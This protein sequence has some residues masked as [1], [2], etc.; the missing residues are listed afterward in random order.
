M[1]RI[2][3]FLGA[4]ALAT[5]AAGAAL[6]EPGLIIDLGGKFDKSFNESA[7]T[8]AQRWMED[9]G[10]SYRESEL[11]SEAQREQSMRRMAESGAN[12]VVVLGFANASTLE[13]V[14][15][16][17]PDTN[18][19]IVDMVV[20]APNVQSVVFKEHEGSYL[21][22]VLAAMASET[23]TVSFVGGMDVPLISKFACGYAQG[24]KAVKPDANVIVNMTGTT[25]TAWNDPVRGAELTRSQISQGS[26]VVY[27]AAGGTGIGVLQAAADEGILSIGVDSNQNHLHP[28]QVLTSMVKRVDNAVYEAFEA[29][30]NGTFEPGIKVMGLDNN[31]V[32]WAQDEY[33][34]DL[35]TESMKATVEETKERIIAGDI[36]VH[37]YTTDSSCPAY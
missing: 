30:M 16:D 5:F 37:D 6:A 9:T 25:P 31:G 33:N 19:T 1:T 29:G 7:F 26:D 13:K 35:I 17:Y 20:D 23:G 11:A 4:T 32:G 18:F 14:A 28:G 27:A 12:P 10:G 3:S 34:A 2:A 8:G 22:G 24:V 36:V 15:P 21:V